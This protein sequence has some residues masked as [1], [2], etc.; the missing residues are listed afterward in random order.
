MG[1]VI[2]V[3]ISKL[4]KKPS[5]KEEGSVRQAQNGDGIDGMPHDSA[6]ESQD[7]GYE[8]TESIVEKRVGPGILILTSSNQLLYKDRRAWELCGEVNKDNGKST[9]GVLP[10]PIAEL[11]SEINK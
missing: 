6:Y 11:C 7:C 10:A 4:D 5:L 3:T 2:S 1:G 9:N 8:L